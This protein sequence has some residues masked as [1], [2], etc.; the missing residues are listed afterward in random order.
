MSLRSCVRPSGPSLPGR[1]PPPPPVPLSAFCSHYCPALT[2]AGNKLHTHVALHIIISI[3][4]PLQNGG[5]VSQDQSKRRNED[6]LYPTGNGAITSLPKDVPGNT[7]KNVFEFEEFID[8]HVDFNRETLDALKMVDLH[9]LS[10]PAKLTGDEVVPILEAASPDGG[11]AQARKPENGALFQ[12]AY[13]PNEKAKRLGRP[14]KHLG[15]NNPSASPE[16]ALQNLET[17]KLLKFRLDNMPLEGPGSRG[18]DPNEKKRLGIIAESNAAKKRKQSVLN[19]S[20]AN[21]SETVSLTTT[22][23]SEANEVTGTSLSPAC[24]ENGSKILLLVSDND[25]EVVAE[26]LALR[27]TESSEV[28]SDHEQVDPIK[29]EGELQNDLNESG[30]KDN[31]FSNGTSI[32]KKENSPKTKRVTLRFRNKITKTSIVREKNRI[33]RTYP[34]PLV[35]VHYDLYDDNLFDTKENATVAD[36]SIALGFP[37]KH[38][39]YLADVAFIIAFL[40]KFPEIIYVGHIGPQDIED[41]LGLTSDLR[42][43]EESGIS[44]LMDD[45]FCKLLTLVLNRKKLITPS[46][47]KSGVEELRKQCFTLGLP[48]EWRDDRFVRNIT[49][50]PTDTDADWVDRSKPPVLQEDNY[51]YQAPLEKLNPFHEPLF[52]EQG[53]AGLPNPRD[54]LIMM[55]CLV[56]WCLSTSNVLK[57]HIAQVV[58]KQEIAGEKDALYASRPI[59]KGFS[60]TTDLKKEL[61]AR[62]SKKGKGQQSPQGTPDPDSGQRYIDPT[63]DPVV[64]P[65]A[66][67]LNEFIVGD[68][69]FKIGRFY[70]VRMAEP[71]GGGL[72]SV[73]R[74]KAITKDPAG[75]KLSIPSKFKLYVEDVHAVLSE[76]LRTL[77]VEF[78]KEGKEVPLEAQYD[79]SK[80]WYEVAS[81]SAELLSFTKHLSQKLGLSSDASKEVSIISQ[82]SVAYRPILYMYQ[83]LS[84]IA[85]L[86]ETFEEMANTH[87]SAGSRSARKKVDYSLSN[88]GYAENGYNDH[89]QHDDDE[90]Y[91]EGDVLDDDDEEYLE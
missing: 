8:R 85:P 26:S 75:L 23:S 74:M 78:D 25:V 34:G 47:Y 52:E 50:V 56:V 68:C 58:N 1:P 19:F 70:L 41:G 48:E 65:M 9:G 4:A 27:P 54:R 69:G 36:E 24:R 15:A 84:M 89:A 21:D 66:L 86:I 61:E 22:T 16:T 60:Q 79:D 3:M 72:S 73:D 90:S 63:S 45:L 20:K 14:R 88:T 43:E 10:V 64:H 32:V 17:S 42:N 62:L 83:Y 91:D 38:N 67:R 13:N 29:T 53:L 80:H 30:S 6:P 31:V 37:V 18:G 76:S 77:G 71:S 12:I 44:R 39:P 49:A 35:P 7:I 40:T 57:S 59:L 87:S 46:N 82:N 28:K 55:R 5:D 81:N 33:T 11:I 51:E 2:V